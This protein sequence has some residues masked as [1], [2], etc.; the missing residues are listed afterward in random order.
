MRKHFVL[1]G[2]ASFLVLGCAVQPLALVLDLNVNSTSLVWQPAT[3]GLVYARVSLVLQ[4]YQDSTQR[5]SLLIAHVDPKK[6][7][8]HLFQ[9]PDLK[10]AKSVGE[11]HQQQG[12]LLT[13]NGA[14][15]SEDFKALGYL[16]ADGNELHKLSKSALFNGIFAIFADGH[17]GLIGRDQFAADQALAPTTPSTI[18]FAIQNGPILLDD[19]GQIK[20]VSDD[21]K[22]ASRTA[23]GLDKDGNI[24]VILL[25]QTLLDT[26]NTLTLYQFAHLLKDAALLQ[27]LGL[28]A[29][30][31]LDGGPSSGLMIDGHYYAEMNKV[32]NVITVTH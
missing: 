19:Q 26:D 24:V 32:Q 6:F 20:I 14:F 11:I 12:S 1:L 18:S 22:L 30:L 27:P 29:V 2:L 8:F 17:A 15:F 4:N 31:N 7:H 23:L 9:N 21:G 3:D 28:H 5:R 10:T 13:F 16:K 25:K